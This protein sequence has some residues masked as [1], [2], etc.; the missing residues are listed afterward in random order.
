MV[1]T[2]LLLLLQNP[3]KDSCYCTYYGFNILKTNKYLVLKNKYWM[4]YITQSF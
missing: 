4:K 2:E 3:D 1:S